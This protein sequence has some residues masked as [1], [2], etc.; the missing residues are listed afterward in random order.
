MSN[1][2]ESRWVCWVSVLIDKF[3]P[4]S[5]FLAYMVDRFIRLLLTNHQV[6]YMIVVASGLLV[7]AAKLKARI[8]AKSLNIWTRWWSRLC[9]DGNFLKQYYNCLLDQLQ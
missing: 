1:W 4:S 3:K 6:H 7:L 9:I 5:I 2:V 8:L